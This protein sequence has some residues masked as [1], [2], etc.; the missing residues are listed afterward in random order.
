MLYPVVESC[1]P[2]EVLKARDRHRLNREVPD[3][4]A[5]EKEKILENLMTFLGHE[6]EGEEHRISAENGFGSRAKREREREWSPINRF[7]KVNKRM[8]VYL[9]TNRTTYKLVKARVISSYQPEKTESTDVTRRIILNDDIPVYQPSRRLSYV[10]KQTVNKHIE[11][12]LEQG[13]IRP[14]SS[15]YASPIVLVKKK[16]GDSRLC[17]DYRQLNLKLVKDRFP[18]PLIDDVLDRL[19]QAKV[20]TTL[21]LKNGFFMLT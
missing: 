16:N 10:K 11:E 12:W 8:Y 2:A 20:Y 21:D 13:I 3:D 5:L 1:L 18:L 7:N 6:V 4:L 15:E 17:V 19:Q 14:S 9:L